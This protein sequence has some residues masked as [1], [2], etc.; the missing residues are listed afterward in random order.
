MVFRHIVWDWNGTLLDDAAVCVSILNELLRARGLSAVSEESYAEGFCFPVEDFYREIGFD[1]AVESYPEV[2]RAYMEVY[3]KR[4]LECGLRRGAREALSAFAEMGLPQSVLTAYR[5]QSL[6]EMIEHF[7]LRDFFGCLVGLEDDL[8]V[9]KVANGRRLLARFDFAPDETLLVGDTIHDVEVARATG[10]V[11]VL[12]PSG[13][14]SLP[15]LQATGAPVL[16]GLEEVED[17]VRG[18]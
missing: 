11:C 8:A 7:G 2:A 15:R 10:M 4:R 18:V 17:Y 13:H 14:Q 16:A 6:E 3:G 5:Q 9:S 12:A 1:F